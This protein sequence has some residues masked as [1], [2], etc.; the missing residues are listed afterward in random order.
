M[1]RPKPSRGLPQIPRVEKEDQRPVLSFEGIRAGSDYCLSQWQRD[2]VKSAMNTL[3]MF[4]SMRWPDILR[5]GGSLGSK[6]GMGYTLYKNISF[7]EVGDDVKVHGIR[8]SD[9]ARI[10]GH[11]V[12]N[13]WH[14][15]R[16]DREKATQR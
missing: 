8:A 1:G 13:T 4:C 16:F 5:T 14:V 12:G 6:Q 3:R 11:R 9:V 15:I 7:P 10:Y 2:E